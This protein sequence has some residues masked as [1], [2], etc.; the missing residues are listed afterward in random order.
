MV[1]S[2]PFIGLLPPEN[3]PIKPFFFL[4]SESF[5]GICLS[6]DRGLPCK[7]LRSKLL[8]DFWPFASLNCSVT[9]GW[10]LPWSL[11]RSW[12][13]W[14]S[15]DRE[16]HLTQRPAGPFRF[17]RAGQTCCNLLGFSKPRECIFFFLLTGQ[18]GTISFLSF[19]VEIFV[20]SLYK[21]P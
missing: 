3:I 5:L 8:E 20:H 14:R 12:E 16:T 1:H 21:I 18:S 4:L 10:C 13:R 17:S 9:W 15:W 19:P 6:T 7:P 2:F 11:I